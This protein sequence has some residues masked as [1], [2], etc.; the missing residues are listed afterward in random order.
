MSEYYAVVRSGSSLSHYGT[1]G[2]KWGVRR[3]QKKDGTMTKRGKKKFGETFDQLNDNYKKAKVTA[4]KALAKY[5]DKSSKLVFATE[6]GIH[7]AKK[8]WAKAAKRVNQLEEI[9]KNYRCSK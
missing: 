1:K 8:R 3:Y 6:F 5:A 4:D 2:M 9:R 7:H